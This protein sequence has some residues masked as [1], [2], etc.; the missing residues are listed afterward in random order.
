MI[1]RPT[2]ARPSTSSSAGSPI[3]IRVALA[4]RVAD[5]A[6]HE[7]VAERGAGQARHV[8]GLAGHQAEREALRRVPGGC[9]FRH[10][11]GHLFG[12]RRIERHMTLRQQAR[13]SSA[14]ARHPW[15]RAPPRFRAAPARRR[16]SVERAVGDLRR[17]VFDGQL[18]VGFEPARHHIAGE[19]RQHGG[20]E[21]CC[22]DA[23]AVP[24]HFCLQFRRCESLRV[25]HAMAQ[26]KNDGG[27]R[28][29]A[30]RK[31]LRFNVVPGPPPGTVYEEYI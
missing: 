3:A 2:Q 4:H 27:N 28:G 29:L 24:G 26:T 11:H 6:E 13:R 15:R 31:G 19:R 22:S 1:A 10:R 14:P 7:Q 30:S 12:E 9:R 21:Q 16:I 25:S 17:I 8:V 18:R 5:V 20:R 23:R